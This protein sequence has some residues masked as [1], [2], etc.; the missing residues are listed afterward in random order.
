VV[1]TVDLDSVEVKVSSCVGNKTLIFLSS[2][3]QHSEKTGLYTWLSN[4]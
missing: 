1:S 3:L 2:E 4:A